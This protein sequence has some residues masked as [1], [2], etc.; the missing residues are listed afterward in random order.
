VELGEVMPTRYGL[1]AAARE[2]LVESLEAFK[3]AKVLG[4]QPIGYI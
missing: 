1:A 4:P 3:F 2:L